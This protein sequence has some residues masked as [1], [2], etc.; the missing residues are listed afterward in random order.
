[1]SRISQ[2]VK[3]LVAGIS[4]QPAL[5]RLPEQLETQVNGF[6]TEASGLQKRPPTC[7][8]AD[9]GVPFANPEPLVHIANRDEDERYMMIFDGTGV[10]IYDLQGH[11]KTVKYEGN[12]QQY[13][14][15]SKPRTQLRLVTIADYTFIV[16]RNFKVTMGDKKVSSTWDD[17]AC[18][19][20]VKSGQYGRTY[21]IFIN[22]ENV[23]SFTTPNGDNAED[24]KKIDTNFIRDR[25][26]EK[27]RE[28]GWQTQ[29]VNSAFYMRKED[30]HINSC[31]CD[32][33]FNGNALFAIFHSVQKFTNLPVTAVQGYTVKVIGNS[34]SDADDYYVSYDATDNVWKECARPGI[35][36]GFNNSTMPHTL[37]RNADGSF[38]LK[39]VSWDERKSGDDDSNPHPSF[40]NNNINDIF[41]FRNRLGVLSGENVI[42]S[43]SASFFDFWGASAVEVQDTDPIDLAV[44]DNQVSILYHAVPFSTGL[45]LFSQNSQFILSVDGVLSPQNASVP[46]TTSFACDVAVAPKTVGRRIYFI[47]KRALY[48]SVREYYTMDDTRGTKDAQ[49]ITSHVPSLLKNGIYDIYSCGNENIVLLPSVGDTSKLYVY[50]FLFADDERLQSSWSYWEFDKAAVLGGG[51]IGSELYLLLNRDNRL[52][53]EKVIFTYNTKDY[54][55]EP[56]RVFLDRKAITAPIPAANYDDINHQTIL[57]LG[58]SYNHA[59]PDGTYYGVVTPDKHYFEFSAEDVKADKCYLHGNYVGQKVTIGQVYTFRID[60]STIYVKRKTDAGVVADDEGRLQLTNAKINFEET[61]VFEVKV[62]HKDNRADNKYY[63][64]GR[65]LGQAANKLGIIP[66]ETGAMLFPIM[67]VN[68]NCIISI[69]SRA[70]TPVSLMEWTWSGNYQKRTHSI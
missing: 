43:R 60:F 53:M 62:S 7:Y 8:I 18:L 38:T 47:V 69:S 63:H 56:Y 21:T 1:M 33:G 9:L 11:K 46:H 25:L 65:V 48:S 2:T 3:N 50:K 45:V 40:V 51:F 39:E 42:L 29:L 5:L 52:F 28:K 57:H 64:T 16:N 54:E 61:G 15:V 58:A 27:A 41:L 17:H 36:A 70:P 12:A 37:V 6:S 4:Q 67:S 68:S 23:A 35:L 55:D 19:I 49:D 59:V 20:N 26:A 22:G 10:S 13:L 31:S 44:S 30:I 34:G 32:D 66:L 24:A 14:T